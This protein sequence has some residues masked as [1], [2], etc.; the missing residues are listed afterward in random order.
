M[1]LENRTTTPGKVG[2]EATATPETAATAT[3][4]TGEYGAVRR[5]GKVTFKANRIKVAVTKVLLAIEVGNAAASTRVRETV[6]RVTN[7]VTG[8][9]SRRRPIRCRG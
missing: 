5:N 6:D 2:A 7:W 8:S 9:I 1:G 3:T 4:K